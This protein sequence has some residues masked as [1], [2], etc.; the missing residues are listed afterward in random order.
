MNL[1]YI[2]YFMSEHKNKIKEIYTQSFPKEERFPFW[3]LKCCSKEKNV[4]FNG[5]VD[6]NKIIG[7][8]YIINC[9]D[10]AYLMYLAIDEKN[11]NNGYGTKI[12]DDLRKKHKTIILSIEKSDKHLNDNRKKRKNF[13]LKNGFYETNLFIEE[14]SI[15]YEV[16]C[17]NK[18]YTITK[19]KLE[20]RYTKMAKSTIMKWL[21]GKFF[22]DM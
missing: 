4:T 18:D 10:Y 20:E 13:Y 11:R 8:E 15:Q 21:I 3:I 2:H 19:E 1:K 17:T 6:N 9:S 14:N 7:I 5:I 12:L 22:S 16:L